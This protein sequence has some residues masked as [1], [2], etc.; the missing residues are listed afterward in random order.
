[1]MADGSREHLP[2]GLP[3]LRGGFW[4]NVLPALLWTLAIF[5]GGSI[6]VSQPDVRLGITFDKIEHV[7]AFFALQVFCYRALLYSVPERGRTA[8]LW[9][10]ALSALLVGI[11]LEVFQFGL[12]DRSA[13][14]AD[15]VAD[16]IGAALAALLLGWVRFV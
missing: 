7:L 14:L 12:P 11:A 2:P 10:G 5:V 6:G 16:G 3:H 15:A 1:M 13:E 4:L 8:L 9:L